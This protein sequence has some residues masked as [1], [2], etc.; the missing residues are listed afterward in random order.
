MFD[1]ILIDSL[2]TYLATIPQDDNRPRLIV[3]HQMGSHRASLLFKRVPAQFKGVPSR[4]VTPMPFGA[5]VGMP[6]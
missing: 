1:D 2:K 5:V 4:P 3:L 6:C